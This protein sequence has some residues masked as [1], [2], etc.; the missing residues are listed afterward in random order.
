MRA[1]YQYFSEHD[2][3]KNYTDAI[4][5]IATKS[6]LLPCP[7]D[8]REIQAEKFLIEHYMMFVNV[9]RD[10]CKKYKINDK[11][12]LKVVPFCLGDIYFNRICKFNN[13]SSAQ[14]LQILQQKTEIEQESNWIQKIKDFL[15][16]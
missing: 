15:N 1:A 10:A 14:I 2:I 11:C 5:I 6:D 3:F 7:K 16:R 9:L 13:F 8:Q 12:E 4:Y